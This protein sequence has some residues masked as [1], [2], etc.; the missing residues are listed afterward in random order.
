MVPLGTE[1][2]TV[3]ADISE[4]VTPMSDEIVGASLLQPVRQR[5]KTS[6]KISVF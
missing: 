1:E 5:E 4:L 2:E 6:S 3:G